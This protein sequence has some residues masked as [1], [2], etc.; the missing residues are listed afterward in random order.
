MIG[1]IKMEKKASYIKVYKEDLKR[2]NILK[3]R[4]FRLYTHYLSFVIW[5]SRKEAIFGSTDKS[6]R[7]IKKE[8]LPNWSV[9]K[10]YEVQQI[11]IEK[12]FLITR[13]DRRM[14]I[15]DFYLYRVKPEEATSIFRNL[16]QG[17]Q[18]PEHLVQNPENHTD[19]EGLQRLQKLKQEAGFCGNSFRFPN[20]HFS[21]EIKET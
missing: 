1:K 19:H 9:G 14:G 3:D 16:E 5:D 12:G 2:L 4:E 7:E 11:L 6:I 10:I 21:K 15:K 17:I 18:V 8:S 20:S 13:P